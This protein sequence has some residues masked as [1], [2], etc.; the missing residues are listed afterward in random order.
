MLN[1]KPEQ[2]KGALALGYN[3]E[4]NSAPKVVAKGFGEIAEK[5]IRIAQE[6]K[7]LIHNDQLL[8][9]SL[10]RLEVGEEIPVKMYQVIA[11][12]LAYIYKMNKQVKRGYK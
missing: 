9:N 10:Y 11:E 7:I 1:Y 3:P 5:I 12:L 8:F 4:K 2:R 6:N